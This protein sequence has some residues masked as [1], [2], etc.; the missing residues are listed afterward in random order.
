MSRSAI[1]VPCR[2]RFTLLLFAST[3]MLPGNSYG[4]SLR[5]LPNDGSLLVR[6]CQT[7]IKVMDAGRDA[8]EQD[9]L[10]A[11]FCG[12]YIKGYA[13]ALI[14]GKEIC[15][16]ADVSNGAMVRVY[17][18]Y[19]QQHPEFL[20]Q[21]QSAGVRAALKFNYSCGKRKRR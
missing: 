21:Y 3:L 15:A 10:P 11:Q 5:P 19:M 1:L 6:Q 8:S 2:M 12:G 7:T 4:T 14:A 17:S 9:I 18:S 16:D 20:K 13:D